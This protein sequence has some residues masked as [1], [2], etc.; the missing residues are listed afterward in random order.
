M[1]PDINR[2]VKDHLKKCGE[3]SYMF[4]KIKRP[5]VKLTFGELPR[6]TNEED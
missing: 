1:H 2:R 4:E 3:W 6:W 5:K